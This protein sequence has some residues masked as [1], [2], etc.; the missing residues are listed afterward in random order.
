MESEDTFKTITIK[1]KKQWGC[2]GNPA[3][4]MLAQCTQEPDRIRHRG[5]L[6]HGCA[7][8][9]GGCWS[10]FSCA[11]HNCYENQINQSDQSENNFLL[12]DQLSWYQHSLTLTHRPCLSTMLNLFSFS[13][14]NR[15]KQK[16]KSWCHYFAAQTVYFLF[17]F[18]PFCNNSF[19]M[20]KMIPSA[21]HTF[22][23]YTLKSS[24]FFT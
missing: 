19:T 8:L 1:K 21:S 5:Q 14:W 18:S 6:P 15:Y 24:S 17:T 9:C 2:P 3:G 23:C 12:T 11:Q 22:R 7:L 13:F 4:R 20:Y 16:K 10:V